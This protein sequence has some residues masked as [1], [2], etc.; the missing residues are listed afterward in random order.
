MWCT[1]IHKQNLQLDNGG[2]LPLVRTVSAL[3]T[4]PEHARQSESVILTASLSSVTVCDQPPGGGFGPPSIS[5]W[6]ACA[7]P[8]RYIT[9]S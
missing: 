9:V 4:Q 3:V 5:S 6:I 7:F 8:S 2:N 1:L